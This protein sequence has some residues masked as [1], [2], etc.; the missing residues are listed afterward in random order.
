MSIMYNYSAIIDKH[1]FLTR[2][3]EKELFVLLEQGDS[4]ERKRAKETIVFSNVRLVINIA[5]D[6]NHGVLE[7]TDLVEFGMVGLLEAIERFNYRRGYKFST[8]AVYWI[9]R[10]VRQAMMQEVSI[11]KVYKDKLFRCQE[12]LSQPGK[13]SLEEIAKALNVEKLTALGIVQA[14]KSSISLSL[15]AGRNSDGILEEVITSRNSSN[16]TEVIISQYFLKKALEELFNIL[17]DD[18]EREVLKH[19]FGFYGEATDLKDIGKKL[20]LS[21][22]RIRQIRNAA[23]E[24]IREYC[25]NNPKYLRLWNQYENT[26][27]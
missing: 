21:G 27:S 11:F 9:K 18:R 15:P 26:R 5:K 4:K 14:I 1:P 17:L 24:K 6:Y 12:I 16:S 8:Y 22:E 25:R 23:I 19:H 7:I 13:L 10:C 2:E 3:E 20:K